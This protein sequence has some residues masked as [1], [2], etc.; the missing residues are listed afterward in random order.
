MTAVEATKVIFLDNAKNY[1]KQCVMAFREGK[2]LRHQDG[3]VTR[4]GEC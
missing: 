2:E 1:V 3:R 4:H